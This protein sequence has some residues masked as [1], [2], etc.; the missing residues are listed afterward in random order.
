MNLAPLSSKEI[1]VEG[2]WGVGGG[3]NDPHWLLSAH[4]AAGIQDLAP[5]QER[6]DCPPGP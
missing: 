1:C 2:H 6:K 5:Q 4:W 3:G